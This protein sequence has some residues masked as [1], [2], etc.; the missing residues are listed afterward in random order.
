MPRR[1][2]ALLCGYYGM[3]NAGDEFLASASIAL[4]ERCGLERGQIAM[5]SGNAAESERLHGVRAFDRWSFRE[6]VAAAKNSE[7]LLLGGGGIFQDSSGLLSPWYYWGVMKIASLCGCCLWAAGQSIGP[8]RSP[9]SRFLARNAFSACSA[10]TVRD[11][12]S[13]EF[14]KRDCLLADDLVLTLPDGG[15]ERQAGG[16]VL[17][18]LRP[19]G[20]LERQAALDLAALEWARGRKLIG[21]AMSGEDAQLMEEL[22][23]EGVLRLDELRLCT[24]ENWRDAF[25]GA[26]YAWGMRLHFGV[27]CLKCGIPCTLVPYDPKVSDFAS[28]WGAN[29][30]P[31][32]S[33]PEKWRCAAALDGA[34]R[35]TAE[36]FAECF[37]RCVSA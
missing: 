4:L 21:V 11:E 16:A 23:R 2:K 7:T 33:R 9:V 13:Y 10:V 29:V 3:G 15:D 19:C 32:R 18:N 31:D 24:A 22:R 6:I 1:W 5:L 34:V 37:R 26:E 17:V 14:L 8:L 27:F 35:E 20:G 36:A 12:H 25:A 28:R 30:W